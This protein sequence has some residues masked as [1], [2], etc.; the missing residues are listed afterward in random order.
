ARHQPPSLNP[1]PSNRVSGGQPR[2]PATHFTTAED[3]AAKALVETSTIS[4]WHPSS[5]CAVWPEKDGGVVDSELR[6]SNL[7]IVDASVFPLLARGDPQATDIV[8]RYHGL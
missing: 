5:S 1:N 2:D 3:E 7:R 8:M 4:M 6:T